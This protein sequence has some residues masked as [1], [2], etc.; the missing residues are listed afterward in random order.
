MDPFDAIATCETIIQKR[1]LLNDSTGRPHSENV[2]V[3][4][5]LVSRDQLADP[6]TELYFSLRSEAHL[7]TFFG[8]VVSS[9]ARWGQERDTL[10]A[11]ER[12]EL[13]EVNRRIA[14]A[15]ESLAQL[16]DR[17]AE[18]RG[19]DVA[20]HDP[21][22]RSRFDLKH[23]PTLAELLRTLAGDAEA[24]QGPKEADTSDFDGTPAYPA[25]L[26]ERFFDVLFLA[27]ECARSTPATLPDDFNASDA[28]FAAIANSALDPALVDRV[29]ATDVRS[30]RPEGWRLDGL[31][32]EESQP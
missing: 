30:F 10:F 23:R 16:L 26:V 2:I 11:A 9:A 32:F 7:R 20:E 5:L 18:F 3:S 8:L 29:R 31:R 27:L 4:R 19:K 28:T 15:A 24:A 13:I 6:Y 14:E 25:R 22:S 21:A 17:R 1:E 12:A